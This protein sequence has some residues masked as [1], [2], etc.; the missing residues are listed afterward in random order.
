MTACADRLWAVT[1]PDDPAVTLL[2]HLGTDGEPGLQILRV[3]EAELLGT[4]AGEGRVPPD[5]TGARSC[6][7]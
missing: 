6:Q 2:P 3:P 5:E 7:P 4:A 1:R